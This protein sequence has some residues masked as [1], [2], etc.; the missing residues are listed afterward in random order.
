ML[1]GQAQDFLMHVGCTTWSRIIELPQGNFLNLMWLM[2]LACNVE[3][4]K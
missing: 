3:H 2:I 4:L 1:K